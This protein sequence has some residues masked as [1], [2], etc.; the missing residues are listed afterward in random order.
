MH[1]FKLTSQLE[2]QMLIDYNVILLHNRNYTVLYFTNEFNFG[3]GHS[4]LLLKR[5]HQKSVYFWNYSN[6]W[7]FISLILLYNSKVNI[8]FSNS[9]SNRHSFLTKL[10]TVCAC[11]LLNVCPMSLKGIFEYYED[12]ILVYMF[13]TKL[14]IHGSPHIQSDAYLVTVQTYPCVFSFHNSSASKQA[15][16]TKPLFTKISPKVHL[17]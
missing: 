4:W 9:K 8:R 16:G 7:I 10:E 6:K 17:N 11:C 15:K 1:R 13:L 3:H 12:D 5:I 14:K 2:F